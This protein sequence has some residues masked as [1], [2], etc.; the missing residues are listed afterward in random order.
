METYLYTEAS[1]NAKALVKIPHYKNVP[2]LSEDRFGHSMCVC[3]SNLLFGIV[4][5]TNYKPS[6]EDDDIEYDLPFLCMLRTSC[7]KY[8]DYLLSLTNEDSKPNDAELIRRIDL[9]RG[10]M[11]R[12]NVK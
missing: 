2:N 6:N 9:T 12:L 8:I 10:L 7:Q 1:S 3:Y 5:H 4:I 11:A